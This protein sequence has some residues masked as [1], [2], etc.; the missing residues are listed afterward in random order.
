METRRCKRCTSQENENNEIFIYVII[1]ETHIVH[2]TTT[3]SNE[4]DEK[5]FRIAQNILCKD[6]LNSNVTSGKNDET[7]ALFY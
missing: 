1:E 3:R 7:S 4:G 2:G 6:L 5:L